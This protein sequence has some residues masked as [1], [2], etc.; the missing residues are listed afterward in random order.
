MPQWELDLWKSA[1]LI[2]GPLDW[3]REDFLFA[4]LVQMQCVG[5]RPLGDFVLFP[6]PSEARREEE[7]SMDD[8]MAMFGVYGDKEE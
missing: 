3:R 1:F 5:G 2:Y 4:R 6:D 8:I 7:K